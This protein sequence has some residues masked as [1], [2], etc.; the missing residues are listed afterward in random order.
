MLYIFVRD[1]YLGFIFN[2]ENNSKCPE[3]AIVDL[4]AFKVKEPTCKP[5]EGWT[6]LGSA[7]A[8]SMTLSKSLEL[9]GSQVL[10][11]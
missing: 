1:K 4:Q 3:T 9:F 2:T 10:N 11:Q 5:G 6:S 8:V 7:S